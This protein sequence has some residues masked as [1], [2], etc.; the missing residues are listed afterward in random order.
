VLPVLR[1]HPGAAATVTDI[2]AT[3]LQQLLEAAQL[4]GLDSSRLD[5][6]VADGT[7]PGLGQQLAGCNADVALIMFTLSAVPPDAMPQMLRNAW[8]ALRPGGVLCIRDHGLYDM[9]QLRIP[10][11][12]CIGQN[13]YRRGDSTLAYFFTPQELAGMAESVGFEVVESDWVCVYNK[14]RKTGQ[15]LKRVFVHG[16]F[17]RPAA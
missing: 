17:R 10:A 6:F 13:T 2:S 7:D 4:L 8:L 12:Q 16:V 1:S 14:N 15:Q 3:C 5:S 11:E 9:V